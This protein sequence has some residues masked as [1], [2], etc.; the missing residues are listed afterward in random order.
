MNIGQI[1]G[2]PLGKEPDAVL[3]AMAVAKKQGLVDSYIMDIIPPY[4]A[5]VPDYIRQQFFDGYVFY[6]SV[7]ECGATP[8]LLAL[9][10]QNHVPILAMRIFAGGEFFR[11]TAPQQATL[12]EL[13]R[14]SGCVDKVEFAMRFALSMPCSA[15]AIAGTSKMTNLNQLLTAARNFKPLDPQIINKIRAMLRTPA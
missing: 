13:F 11:G 12:D 9:M 4:C 2:F 10:E 8:A 15:T 6:Y 5:A 3:A 7:I 1:C 14:Q